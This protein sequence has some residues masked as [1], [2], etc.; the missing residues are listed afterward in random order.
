MIF[1]TWSVLMAFVSQVRGGCTICMVFVSATVMLKCS[2]ITVSMG[3]C[4]MANMHLLLLSRQMLMTL[5]LMRVSAG[6]GA[7]K[8]TESLCEAKSMSDSQAISV[9]L[10]T[11]DQAWC[12]SAVKR[13]R[14]LTLYVFYVSFP[15]CPAESTPISVCL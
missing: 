1:M 13:C 7:T 8:I 11:Y 15:S 5:A 2:N 3:T 14:S 12:H 9:H 10:K 6:H 4:K